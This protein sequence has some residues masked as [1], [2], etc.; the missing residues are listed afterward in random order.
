MLDKKIA[1]RTR[2]E[3]T[4]DPMARAFVEKRLGKV[5]DLSKLQYDNHSLAMSRE[6]TSPGIRCSVK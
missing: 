1:E 5:L 3:A 2:A 4:V 6:G